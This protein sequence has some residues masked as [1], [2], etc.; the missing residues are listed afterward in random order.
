MIDIVINAT[1]RET[2]V[3]LLE[4]RQVTEVF[5]ERR[6]DQGIV[7]NIYRGRVAK[8]LPGMQAAFVDIGL[9]KAGFLHVSDVYVEAAPVPVPLELP[10]PAPIPTAAIEALLYEGQEILVQVAKEPLGTKGCRLTA[11]LSLAGRYLVLMP[12]VE[13]I[14]ISRRITDAAEQERLRL[15]L[16]ALCPAGM[17]CIART[18][19]A[20]VSPEALEAD[21]HFLSRLWEHLQDKARTM[22]APCLVH[23]E[24]DLVLRTLRDYLTADV[25]RVILDD[26]DTFERARTF[27]QATAWPHLVSHLVLYQA[28]TPLFEAFGVE[29][30]IE[31]ALQRKIWLK[32]GGYIIIE[33]TEALVAID[34]N[35][36]RFVGTH[37][38]EATMLTTNLE[39]V[40]EI[41]RQLRLRN[42][43][44]LVVID[45]IDMEIEE[46]QQRVLQALEQAVQGDR[47]HTKVLALSAFGVVEMT[48]KRVRASLEQMLCEPCHVCHGTGR[49]ES[50]ATLCGKVLREIQRVMQVTPHTKKVMVTVPPVVAAMLY[51]EEKVHIG[52]VEERYQVTLTIHSENDLPQGHFEVLAL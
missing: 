20:G 21:L 25:E 43:G 2:R 4:Q 8:I 17:G 40:D 34:V 30:E 24:L 26:P 10:A 44:G 45:F 15:C 48:R 13:H 22:L 16:T 27:M 7:G 1:P 49:V 47:A 41:V 9:A 32:S 19:S 50:T 36:G 42:I 12:G 35:T 51:N 3:A 23:Q 31:R 52:A 37:D 39:A 5:I 46:H 38:P 33:H 6:T 11:Y 28:L 29:R 14:G 18:L